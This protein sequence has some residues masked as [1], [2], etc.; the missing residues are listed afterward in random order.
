MGHSASL[1]ADELLTVS[2]TLFNEIDN[3]ACIVYELMIASCTAW[4]SGFIAVEITLS[5]SDSTVHSAQHYWAYACYK[6][7]YPRTRASYFK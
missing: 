4:F 1:I 7:A 3:I 2:P 5:H 6:T